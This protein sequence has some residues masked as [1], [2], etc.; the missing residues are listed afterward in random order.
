MPG[1]D[2]DPPTPRHSR[3]GLALFAVYL[4]LYGGFVL[5]SAFAPAL[6]EQELAAG[7]NLA[8]GYGLGLIA[9]ALGLALLYVWL[10]R[11]GG[12]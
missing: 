10:C 9:A 11:E 3:H 6:M 12:G 7:I 4:A 8:V 1:S 5:L 2:R